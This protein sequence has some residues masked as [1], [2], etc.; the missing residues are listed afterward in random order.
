MGL[1]MH[2]WKLQ[3]QVSGRH[4]WSWGP[5]GTGRM[6]KMSSGVWRCG[7]PPRRETEADQSF[8]T[9]N[10]ERK[11]TGRGRGGKFQTKPVHENLRERVDKQAYEHLEWFSDIGTHFMCA[12]LIGWLLIQV[13]QYCVALM[14]V[15][16]AFAPSGHPHGKR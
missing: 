8:G 9:W 16:M 5:W 7:R 2:S 10:E 12:R 4:F 13:P 14:T 3:F 11:L 1:D 15:S 6:Q